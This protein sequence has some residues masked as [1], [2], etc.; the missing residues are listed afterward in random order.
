MP[1]PKYA[2]PA[3]N[4]EI[5]CKFPIIIYMVLAVPNVKKKMQPLYKERQMTG[6]F[7]RHMKFMVIDMTIPRWS[8]LIQPPRFALFARS[9]VI[10]GN[11]Q[12]II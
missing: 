8:M 11:C 4:M 6:S 10:S 1:K 9:M 5:L 12:V 7:K 2:L 3:R